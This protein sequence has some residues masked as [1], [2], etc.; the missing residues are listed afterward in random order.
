MKRR[1]LL[2]SI[3]ALAAILNASTM[4]S[5]FSL[6]GEIRP[7]TEYRHGFKKLIG[8]DEEA[9]FFT[10]Q[11]SR[12]VANYKQDQLVLKLSLQD[13]R[14]WGS[15][16][17][18]YKSESALTSFNEAWA[19]FYFKPEF[20]IKAG[21]QEL[22][23]NNA[24][25]LGNLGWAQQSRSH[26]ALLFLYTDSTFQAHA[27]FAFNQD[28]STPEYANLTSTFYTGVSN[29]K[30]MQYV[31]LNKQFNTNS[32]SFLFF[33]NGLQVGTSDSSSVN[34]SQTIGLTGTFKPGSLSIETELYY[35]AGTDASDKTISAYLLAAS[36]G[37]TGF[38]KIKPSIGFDVLSGTESDASDNNSFTPLY[39][40]N[41]KFYGLMDYF[42]VGNAH[43]GV[44]LIDL[45]VKAAIPIKNKIKIISHLHQFLSPVSIY[46][47]ES[48]E[49]S[50][51]LG[52]EIDFIV[53][54]QLAPYANLKL[55]YSQMF[56]TET[57]EILKGGNKDLTSNWSWVMLTIK[58]SFFKSN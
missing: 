41:H 44:G 29:Y 15:S 21:R 32:L 26:D 37:Y 22:N 30:T 5:Q 53:A 56:A 49:Q 38:D 39:G 17:Q 35:Q 52:T 51:S 47:S 46:N 1:N 12:L 13:V 58:P 7:R 48:I 14:I 33:N 20:S 3:I 2:K 55:G 16:D 19:Q 11:R 25:F 50:S 42:Y 45:Y 18:I 8:D 57:M 40:T 9:A 10:E 31:W 27:G 23:Y 28:A 6:S 43:G 54:V 36:V 4:F 34:Y 24:R